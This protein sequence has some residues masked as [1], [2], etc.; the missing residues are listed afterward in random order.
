MDATCY[1]SLVWLRRIFLFS[2]LNFIHVLYI[3]Q[4]CISFSSQMLYSEIA[5]HTKHFVLSFSIDA[6]AILSKWI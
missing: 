2:I 3:T 4:F 6:V 1:V 5:F